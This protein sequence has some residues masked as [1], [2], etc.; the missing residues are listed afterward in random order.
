MDL[1]QILNSINLSWEGFA[2][3]IFA[4]VS[5]LTLLISII[6][7]FHWKRYGMGGFFLAVMEIVYA[8]AVVLLLSTA[9]FA[10]K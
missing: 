8:V 2:D 6:F 10:L 1:F 3:L 7:F 5:L 9:F 4:G